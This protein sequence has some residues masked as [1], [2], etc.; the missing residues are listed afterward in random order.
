[1][2]KTSTKITLALLLL[3]WLLPGLVGRGPWMSD[4]PYSLGLVNHILKTGDWV[5]PT[6]AGE[7]FMEK[8]PL[9]YVTAAALAKLA[10]PPLAVH[11]AVR[12]ASGL[13][14]LL[15][16]L[17]FGLSARELLGDDFVSSALLLLLGSAA[18]QLTAHKLITDVALLSGFAASLYGLAL[19]K[20]RPDLGGFWIGTGVGIGF[21]S[22]GLLAPGVIGV[23]ALLLPLIFQQWRS[24]DYLRSL[25]IA[26]AA[27]LPW[28]IVWPVLLYRRSPALFT[29]WFWFENIGR[30]IGFYQG[31]KPHALA[32]FKNLEMRR[33]ALPVLPLAAWSFWHSRR[34]WRA[35]PLFQLST[36]SFL[37]L[38]LVLGFSS[39]TRSLYTL[40]MLL[41]L[42]L[43]AAAGV[44][45][46]PGKAARAATRLNLLLF[47]SFAALLWFGWIVILS[48]HPALAAQKASHLYGE[49]APQFSV[50]RFVAALFCTAVGLFAWSVLA[51]QGRQVIASWTV[52]ITLAWGLGMTL[53]LPAIDARLGSE[54]VFTSLKEALPTGFQCV[55]SRNLGENERALVEYY[56]G[57]DTKRMEVN[58]RAGCD[59]LL[60]E[61]DDDAPAPKPDGRLLWERTKTVPDLKQ[62]FRLYQKTDRLLP[63]FPSH[64]DA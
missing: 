60:L 40:P 12:L 3:A 14:M 19:C 44:D 35:M 25:L 57:I 47:G 18:L 37:V 29:E 58:D 26:L 27:A 64:R 45:A 59:L 6:L 32:G 7:P 2:K 48:G 46:L 4:E 8:P 21:L 31:G 43:M 38:F 9:Y 51:R 23:T 61:I 36:T 50:V 42:A 41:P 52:G 22:K 13:Y 34:S 54:A 49:S 15:T 1:M 30:F 55:A 11:D 17:F 33:L 39:N 63:F 20:R 62:T 53:W 16:L 56:T 5:V 28:L 10:S 24:R